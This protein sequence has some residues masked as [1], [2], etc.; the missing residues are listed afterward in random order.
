MLM[1]LI[2][3]KRTP[4]V[5]NNLPAGCRARI[6]KVDGSGD[7]RARLAAMGITP[8]TAIEVLGCVCGRQLV[9]VRGCN[10]VLDGDAACCVT[11]RLETAEG[12]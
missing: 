5:L 3:K 7:M 1:S 6:S 8:E 12:S 4:C 2:M 9:K 11:C 10:F